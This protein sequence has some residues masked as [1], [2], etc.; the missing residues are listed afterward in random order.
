MRPLI[1][2]IISSRKPRTGLI[3]PC[4]YKTH[5]GLII[6]IT[7]SSHKPHTGV[8]INLA[9]WTFVP[10]MYDVQH[11]LRSVDGESRRH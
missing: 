1:L 5:K 2:I 10:L 7:I 3:L 9:F 8:I 6:F 11:T 4:I